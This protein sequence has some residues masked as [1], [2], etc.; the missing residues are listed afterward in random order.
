M[1]LYLPQEFITAIIFDKD[2][3]LPLDF[4]EEYTEEK[5]F[6]TI[7]CPTLKCQSTLDNKFNYPILLLSAGSYKHPQGVYTALRIVGSYLYKE[8]K[9]MP[10]V[11][12]K[13]E[14]IAQY[15][16]KGSIRVLTTQG[17]YDIIPGKRLGYLVM[18]GYVIAVIV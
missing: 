10:K 16:L 5:N 9:P 14:E 4:Y 15:A 7:K 1:L 18:T 11:I 6:I 17:K 12:T 2:I 13:A 8:E 3:D